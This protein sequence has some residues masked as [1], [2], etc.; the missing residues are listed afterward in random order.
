MLVL[1]GFAPGAGHA[2]S[3]TVGQGS[4]LAVGDGNLDLG[5]GDLN[6]AGEL[7]LGTGTLDG[8]RDLA[9]PGALT[10]GTGALHVRGDIIAPGTLSTASADLFLED[11]CGRTSWTIANA[12]SLARLDVAS[13]T[14]KELRLPAG[15]TI[16][17]GQSLRLAGGPQLMPV[18]S[19][20]P[21]TAAFLD[22]APGATQSVFAIQ[23]NDLHAPGEWIAPG[24]AQQFGSVAGGN[25]VRVFQ[26]L[27]TEIPALDSRGAAVFALA[28]L[29]A[30][31]AVLK[32]RRFGGV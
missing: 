12:L 2:A 10:A 15:E 14:G 5:C 30:A 19:T 8:I 17:V 21:G 4:T 28:L 16:A 29:L 25:L 7:T 11:G 13:A 32:R 31:F 20:V 22:L 9:V 18:G 26:L 6:V 27:A 3:L 1:V 24:P 23:A